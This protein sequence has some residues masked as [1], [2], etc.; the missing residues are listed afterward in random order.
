ML[1]ASTAEF[2]SS[3]RMHALILGHIVGAKIE[4][5]FVSNKLITYAN[6]YLS[7]S[8]KSHRLK[9]IEIMKEV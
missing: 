7:D 6:Q 2:V 8:A 9:I 4:P 5:I 3:G 1:H